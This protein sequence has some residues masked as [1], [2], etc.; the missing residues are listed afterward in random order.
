MKSEPFRK[1]FFV[2]SAVSCC[3]E[4]TLKSRFMFQKRRV[5]FVFRCNSRFLLDRQIVT[6]SLI[7]RDIFSALEKKSEK[8]IK[9]TFISICLDSPLISCSSAKGGDD[10]YF[11]FLS[12]RHFWLEVVNEVDFCLL[13][14]THSS[15]ANGRQRITHSSSF[16]TRFRPFTPRLT[17]LYAPGDPSAGYTYQKKTL[18]FLIGNSPKKLNKA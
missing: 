2:F 17:K 12:L 5:Q 13:D 3:H 10:S 6:S 4:R 9:N 16:R 7:H 15:H 11:L 8:C 1:T 14:R 18:S